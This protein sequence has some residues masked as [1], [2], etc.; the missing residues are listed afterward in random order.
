[1]KFIKHVMEG[2]PVTANAARVRYG[3]L[4]GFGILL[5]FPRSAPVVRTILTGRKQS[6]HPSMASAWPNRQTISYMTYPTRG[7]SERSR[8]AAIC[9]LT[10]AKAIYDCDPS[11]M[12][13]QEKMS[14]H[15]VQNHPDSQLSD[16]K[17]LISSNQHEAYDINTR[18]SST[19]TLLTLSP[20]P[21]PTHRN[22][23]RR[24]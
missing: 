7:E 18:P 3:S 22:D 23:H 2:G 10:R 14:E 13:R 9:D 8:Q 15:D 16:P 20:L 5:L 21:L 4:R 6:T 12:K 1:M 11:I 19:S 17:A 24:K